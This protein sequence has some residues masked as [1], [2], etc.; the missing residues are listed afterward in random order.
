[1]HIP[2]KD[3]GERNGV[4]IYQHCGSVLFCDT[5]L[6]NTMPASCLDGP[7]SIPLCSVNLTV[8]QV[9]H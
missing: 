5:W 8:M 4:I 9:N 7:R 2:Q 3:I 1:M 6:G